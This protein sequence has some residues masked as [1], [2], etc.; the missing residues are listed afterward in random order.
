MFELFLAITKIVL[1]SHPSHSTTS[2]GELFYKPC[3]KCGKRE[4]IAVIRSRPLM[5]L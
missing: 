3:D 5:W 1:C 4:F 2:D